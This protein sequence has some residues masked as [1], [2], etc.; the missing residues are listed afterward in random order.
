MFRRATGSV[1]GDFGYVP[2]EVVADTPETFTYT[3][4]DGDGDTSVTD[5]VVT[6]IHNLSPVAAADTVLTNIVDG[7]DIVIPEAA[8]LANDSDGGPSRR[9]PGRYTMKATW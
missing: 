9:S 7:S 6:V 1:T 4:L 3:I 8:L 5:L 2:P